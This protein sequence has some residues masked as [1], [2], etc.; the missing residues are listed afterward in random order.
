[1]AN[2]NGFNANNVE[3]A[4]DFDPIPAGKY[5]AAITNSQIKPTKNGDG[6]LLELQFEIIEGEYKGRLVWSRLCLENKNELTVKIAKSQLADIC[7][8]VGVMTPTDSVQLHNLPLQISV[9]V[10][11]RSD[12]DEA[13]NEIKKYSKR[14]VAPVQNTAAAA[15]GI[16][17]WKR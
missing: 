5:I 7:R 10:K 4:D 16:A 13:T 3:P 1:M 2:L 6:S 8:A 11:K 9:K 14:E 15:K 17:P 12:S